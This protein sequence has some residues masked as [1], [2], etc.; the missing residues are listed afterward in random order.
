MNEQH[1]EKHDATWK[2]GDKC[3]K[4]SKP[5]EMIVISK[6]EHEQLKADADKWRE[7]LKR[8]MNAIIYGNSHPE[9]IESKP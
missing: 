6:E 9:A 3:P 8:Q 2:L 7:Q 4:C 1:C 5:T